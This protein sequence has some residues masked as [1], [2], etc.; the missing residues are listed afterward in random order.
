[1]PIR[2]NTTVGE[3]EVLTLAEAASVFQLDEEELR[4]ALQT[5]EIPAIRGGKQWKIPREG[6][7]RYVEAQAEKE[8]VERRKASR[9]KERS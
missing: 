9:P 7:R 8:A 1:M 6:L 2:P 4:E 3:R 5:G